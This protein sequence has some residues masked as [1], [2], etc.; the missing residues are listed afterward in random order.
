MKIK[1]K[2]RLFEAFLFIFVIIVSSLVG[3]VVYYINIAIAV[4][5]GFLPI[6][7]AWSCL[8][9]FVVSFLLTSLVYKHKTKWQT[10]EKKFETKYKYMDSNDDDDDLDFVTNFDEYGFYC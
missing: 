2:N 4:H 7:L 6:M 8:V 3:V 5:F 10:K 1:T 9:T